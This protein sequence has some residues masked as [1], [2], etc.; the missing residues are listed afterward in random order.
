MITNK[1]Q[2]AHTYSKRNK[3]YSVPEIP[4]DE[5]AMEPIA[6]AMIPVTTTLQL[7]FRIMSPTRIKTTRIKI[8]SHMISVNEN[9]SR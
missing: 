1:M 6:T 7:N 8:F 3:A 4:S 9:A 5:E 2:A